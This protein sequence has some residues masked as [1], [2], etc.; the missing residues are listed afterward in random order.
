LEDKVLTEQKN[1]TVVEIENIHLKKVDV[2]SIIRHVERHIAHWPNATVFVNHHECRYIEPPT[3][4]ERTFTSQGTPFEGQLGDVELVVKVAKSPLEEELQ[5]IAVLSQGVWHGTTLAGC[6][7]RPFANYHFG[8]VDVA[9]IASD[10]SPIPPFDMSRS[11]QLNPRNEV[12]A[13]TFAFVGLHLEK[14][15]RELE[16]KD[17]ERRRDE[18]ARR[19]Q[20]QADAIAN[21]INQDFNHWRDEVKQA[22][23]KIAGGGD[24]LPGGIPEPEHGADF[25]FG[26]EEPAEVVS[27][28]G[29]PGIALGDG[30]APGSGPAAG[31]SPGPGLGSGPAVQPSSNADAK[32]GKQADSSKKTPSRRGGFNVEFLNMGKS[33]ARAKYERQERTI[34]VNLEHPQIE[35]ALG[36]GGSEDPIFRRLAYEVAF[37]E[38]AIALASE[39]AAVSYYLD[40][41]EPIVDIRETLNRLARRAAPLYAN[42]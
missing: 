8:S 26:A 39:M 29:G 3:A 38:Y 23:A 13:A 37:A 27:E 1:G 31:T 42:D 30:P 41:S 22:A 28:M 20:S 35:A 17:K 16:S 36:S 9:R 6:E 15:R 25:I 7:R 5:G 32:K 40:V 4:D 2:N 14:V 10:R 33:E 12:V 34:F 18:E 24:R 19:L 11:M 21:L